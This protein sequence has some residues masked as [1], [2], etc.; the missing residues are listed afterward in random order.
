MV[1]AYHGRAT[2]SRPQG[3]IVALHVAA[4]DRHLAR[5][6]IWDALISYRDLLET[7]D[8]SW[9]AEALLPGIVKFYDLPDL[10]ASLPASSST[11][12]A[13][14]HG[15]RYRRPGTCSSTVS[16]YIPPGTAGRGSGRG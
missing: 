5:V 15:G 6:I 16:M 4:M 11:C 10:A 1:L 8:F 9:P 14:T 3:G 12:P 13:K 2:N 7:P